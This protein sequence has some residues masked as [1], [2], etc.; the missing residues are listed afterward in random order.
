V[1]I[2]AVTEQVKRKLLGDRT[3]V[4]GLLLHGMGGVGK[5]TLAERVSTEL[6]SS[7]PGGVFWVRID[8]SASLDDVPGKL[9][10]A[11]Q[12]LLQRLE[13]QAVEQPETVDDG[14]RRLRA[15]LQ[16]KQQRPLLLV[17]DNVPEFSGGLQR[18]LPEVGSILANG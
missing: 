11:Q 18:M 2:D 12:G 1:G 5:S 9:M 8:R 16:Q 4:C 13:K 10:K 7:F 6:K 15:A 17:I 3:G 14:Q